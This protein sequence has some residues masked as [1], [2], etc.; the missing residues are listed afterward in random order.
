[1]RLGG[2]RLGRRAAGELEGRERPDEIRMDSAHVGLDLGQ[3][4]LLVLRLQ[5]LPAPALDD[6]CH[7]AVKTDYAPSLF[8]FAASA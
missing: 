4:G 6:G 7:P 8:P 2:G 1:M 3:Q 5:D